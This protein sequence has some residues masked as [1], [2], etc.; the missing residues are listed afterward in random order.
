MALVFG[1]VDRVGLGQDL[2][3]ELFVV[4]RGVLGRVDV[5]LGAVNRDDLDRDDPG[6]GAQG[7]YLAEQRR[8]RA[9][10]TGPKA[11]DRRVIGHPVGRDD[12]ER[13]VLLAVAFDTPRGTLA[14]RVRVQQQRDHH[15]RI[16]RR[17]APPIGAIPAVEGGQVELVDGVEHEPRPVPLWQP[18]TQT[19]RQQQLLLTVTRQE[20]L[21]HHGIVL[22]T[23]T[24]PVC[25]TATM[26]TGSGR[27]DRP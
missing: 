19:R 1:A 20:V 2:R 12:P 4:A 9:L 7:Q 10:M 26:E 6:L 25:A 18:L 15:R 3:G 21:R 13:D 27:G 11:R 16:V 14:D 24:A 5:H 17:A 8:Q 22:N 23:R